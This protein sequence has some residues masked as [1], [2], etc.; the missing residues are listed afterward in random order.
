MT[1]GKKGGWLDEIV[2]KSG[3]RKRCSKKAKK[4]KSA[5]F[6]ALPIQSS[7]AGPIMPDST[8][9]PVS[10]WLIGKTP[11]T[12]VDVMVWVWVAAAWDNTGRCL[13]MSSPYLESEAVE[14]FRFDAQQLF[15]F[16]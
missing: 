7:A 13:A 15:M 3:N 10:D 2:D 16:T 12:R 14:I 11:C 9:K 5:I 4:Q 1:I 6:P 8:T